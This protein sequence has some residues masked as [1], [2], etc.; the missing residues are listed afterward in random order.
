MACDG[1]YR[2]YHEGSAAAWAVYEVNADRCDLNLL[3]LEY[4]FWRHGTSAFQ[5]EVIALDKAVEFITA[6]V[7]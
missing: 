2:G 3:A 5:A 1:G 6:K 7:R 4:S